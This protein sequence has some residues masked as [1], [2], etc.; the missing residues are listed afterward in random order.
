MLIDLNPT[1]PVD[2]FLEGIRERGW[3]HF[4]QCLEPAFLEELNAGIEAAYTTCHRVQEKN[5]VNVNTDGTVHHLL[6]QQPGFLE[7]IQRLELHAYI[8]AFFDAPYILNSFGGVINLP[9]KASYVCNIH[10]D[11]VI[12]DY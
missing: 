8:R 1:T 5:G 7:F 10:R 3:M 4:G 6:G 2:T 9:H 12:H 11:I